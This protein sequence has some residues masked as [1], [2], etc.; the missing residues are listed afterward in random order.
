MAQKIMVIRFDEDEQEV[1]TSGTKERGDAAT[2]FGRSVSKAIK[3][4]FGEARSLA[5]GFPSE[6][7]LD[8]LTKKLALVRSITDIVPGADGVDSLV[9]SVA[10]VERVVQSARQAMSAMH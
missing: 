3:E 4:V 7:D 10:D 9:R 5:D 2:E 1:L 6:A 8:S